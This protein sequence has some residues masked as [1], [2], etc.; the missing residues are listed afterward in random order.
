MAE[1]IQELGWIDD[2]ASFRYNR[3]V[4]LPAKARHAQT[5]CIGAQRS[6]IAPAAQCPT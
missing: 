1:E 3:P 2:P 5:L 6:G 4:R